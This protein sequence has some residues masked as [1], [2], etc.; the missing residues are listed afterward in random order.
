MKIDKTEALAIVQ[1]EACELV[2]ELASDSVETN[3]ENALPLRLDLFE[4]DPVR[5]FWKPEGSTGDM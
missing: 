5:K 4:W 3:V 2:A 1:F